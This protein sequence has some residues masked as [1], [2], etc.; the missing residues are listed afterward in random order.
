MIHNY[1]LQK[2]I[3]HT[4]CF[5]KV[6]FLPALHYINQ[7]RGFIFMSNSSVSRIL[8]IITCLIGFGFAVI[9][10]PHL[11]D[12]IP[13]HFGDG[14]PNN[15]GPKILI[16]TCP[17]TQLIVFLLGKNKAMLP[18]QLKSILTNRQYEW[19]I[20][21]LLIFILFIEIVIV[22]ASFNN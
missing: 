18:D 4:T 3:S 1:L 10:Y 16:F 13:I 20:F 17:L 7:E 5:I 6:Y 22:L 19:T 11:P 14:V 2:K 21:G 15:F 9:A 8:S 12:T